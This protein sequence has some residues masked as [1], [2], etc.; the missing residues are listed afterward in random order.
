M[1]TLNPKRHNQWHYLTNLHVSYNRTM[2]TP[3]GKFRRNHVK[4]ICLFNLTMIIIG[5]LPIGYNRMNCNFIL[6][7]K[8]KRYNHYCHSGHIYISQ[9]Q[10]SVDLYRYVFILICMY[11]FYMH[12]CTVCKRISTCMVLSLIW[13]LVKLITSQH[14]SLINAQALY[15]NSL[16]TCKMPTKTSGWLTRVIWHFH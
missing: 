9:F 3:H 6:V 16:Q 14:I 4:I 15:Q 5:W 10:G 11:V 2:C 13:D 7:L 12:A 1:L 8:Q